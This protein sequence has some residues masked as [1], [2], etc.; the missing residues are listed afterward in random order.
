MSFTG[1]SSAFSYLYAGAPHLGQVASAS[2]P[3][4]RRLSPPAPALRCR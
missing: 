4:R 1:S 3:H 2:A